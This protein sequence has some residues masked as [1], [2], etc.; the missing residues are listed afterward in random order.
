MIFLLPANRCGRPIQSVVLPVRGPVGELD[1]PLPKVWA[2]LFS[3]VFQPPLQC[4]TPPPH[5]DPTASLVSTESSHCT[6]TT[7]HWWTHHRSHHPPNLYGDVFSVQHVHPDFLHHSPLSVALR[8][9]VS[10][11]DTPWPAAVHLVQGGSRGLHLL[12]GII[13]IMLY[14]SIMSANL[15]CLHVKWMESG[16]QDEAQIISNWFEGQFFRQKWELSQ[17]K[18]VII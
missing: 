11:A 1:L 5:R 4:W 9:D 13:S 16:D 18:T 17:K 6:A 8:G 2:L 10:P 15:C 3:C 14:L 12:S 7:A